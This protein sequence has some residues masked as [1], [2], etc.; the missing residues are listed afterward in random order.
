M[1]AVSKRNQQHER[2]F[3]RIFPITTTVRNWFMWEIRCHWLRAGERD[4]SRKQFFAEWIIIRINST[5][6]V[7]TVHSINSTGEVHT[8]HS[9]NTQETMKALIRWFL[10]WA[11]GGRKWSASCTRRFVPREKN[12]QWPLNRG[13]GVTQKRSG[14][15]EKEKNLYP[16]LGI[17]PRVLRCRV[18]RLS[19]YHIGCI[20]SVVSL[21]QM[22]LIW[23]K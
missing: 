15:L 10:K 17:E 5:G 13:L 20:G 14:I 23:H 9:I 8:V 3:R 7:H 21:L 18:H 1:L 4:R 12:P 2:H 6:E 19:R 16:L 11:L 22:K